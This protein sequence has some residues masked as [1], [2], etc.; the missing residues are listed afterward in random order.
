M[1]RIALIIVATCL[2]ITV[3]RAQ[4][5][6]TTKL[7]LPEGPLKA[8][9]SGI[10]GNVQVRKAGEQTWQR[11]I[12]GM[13]VDEGAEFRTG[14]KSAVR[15]TI[16]PD[17]T[18]TLDRLGTVQILKANFENGKIFTDLGMKYG[19]TRYNIE[20]VEHEHEGQVRSP[21]SVLAIRGT[22]VALY[23]QPPF[24]PQATSLTGRAMFKDAKKQVSV[25]GNGKAKVDQDTD[26]PANYALAQTVNDPRGDFVGRTPN[27]QVAQQ[28]QLS[29]AGLDYS[30]LGVLALLDS[31]RANQFSGSVIGALPIGSQLSFFLSW[32][33]S[34]RSNLDLTV[35]SP[36]GEIVSLQNPIVASSGQ[37]LADGIADD[38]GFGFEQ[39]IWQINHPSGTYNFRVE[40]RPGTEAVATP[41]LFVNEDPDNEGAFAGPF[42]EPLDAANPFFEGTITAPLP[43]NP[44][45]QRTA[46]N[47]T[48]KAS[49]VTTTVN[50]RPAAT[51]VAKPAPA[52]ARPKPAAPK[53]APVQTRRTFR[54]N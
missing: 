17:Q 23:D 32:T 16:P 13:V 54:Q 40:I 53:P 47:S 25:G 50:S 27:E 6:P 31:T 26:T 42:G 45:P 9:V 41:Q 24:V 22:D 14:L 43:P 29:Y 28:L 18:V 3:A 48:A 10:E 4:T 8:T 35:T 20:S 49:T 46:Q 5:Q 12:V 7:T 37:H 1:S 11:A 34:P 30:N 44:N 52:P 21:S 39:V 2:L 51:P 19:R 15:L 38:Q 36:L 33:G